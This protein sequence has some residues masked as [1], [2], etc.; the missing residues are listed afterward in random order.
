MEATASD[1]PL[2]RLLMSS[3]KCEEWKRHFFEDADGQRGKMAQRN[4]ARRAQAET[5]SSHA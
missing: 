5:S 1:P 3:K 4:G 2:K